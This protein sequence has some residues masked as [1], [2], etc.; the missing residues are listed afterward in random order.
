MKINSDKIK[1][2]ILNTIFLFGCVS[3]TFNPCPPGYGPEYTISGSGKVVDEKP[4]AGVD[5]KIRCVRD[6]SGDK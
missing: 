6:D 1:L 5:F 4:E 3:C 2:T